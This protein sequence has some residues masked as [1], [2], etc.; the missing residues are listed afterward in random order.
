VFD[1]EASLER[2]RSQITTIQTFLLGVG[3]VSL[4]VAA[5]SILNVML[6]SAMERREEIGALGGGVVSVGLGAVINQ[7]LLGD[8][9]AFSGGTVRHIP[10]GLGFGLYCRTKHFATGDREEALCSP[11]SASSSNQC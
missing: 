2:V 3:A 1:A 11:V 6:M 5:V 7:L 10:T 4:L 9:M 8:P